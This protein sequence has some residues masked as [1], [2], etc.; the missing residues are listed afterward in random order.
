MRRYFTHA[1]VFKLAK[2][3]TDF[4]AKCFDFAEIFDAKNL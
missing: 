3:V 1:E 4:K 2:A